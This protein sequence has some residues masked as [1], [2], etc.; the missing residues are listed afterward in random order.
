MIVASYS[1]QVVGLYS[2]KTAVR[3]S[4]MGTLDGALTASI[5]SN[6]SSPRLWADLA[7]A[8]VP[9]KTVGRSPVD[10]ASSLVEGV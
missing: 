4:T 5:T 1:M 8:R 2:M 10:S 7:A 6:P 9:A 3:V